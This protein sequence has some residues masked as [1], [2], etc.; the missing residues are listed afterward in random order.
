L[1]G[2]NWWATPTDHEGFD[3]GLGQ[4]ARRIRKPWVRS[5]YA[6]S[7]NE[8]VAT[9]DQTI[10]AQLIEQRGHYRRSARIGVED[11]YTIGSPILRVSPERPRNGAAEE[12]NELTPLHRADRKPKDH[13]EYSRSGPCIAAKAAA[14]RLRVNHVGLTRPMTSQDVRFTSDS[15]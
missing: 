7:I 4:L 2:A 15:V 9:L 5:A 6:A 13:P 12:R 8:Q 10:A 11:A 14:S 3:L 1:D